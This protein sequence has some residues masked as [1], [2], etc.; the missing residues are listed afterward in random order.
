[1]RR[2]AMNELDDFLAKTLPRQI[3]AE[4]A[5]HNGDPALRLGMWSTNDPVTLL[6]A[7]G[8]TKVGSSR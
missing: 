7:W 8:P 4:E 6:G 3:K 1:M 5:L 2:I